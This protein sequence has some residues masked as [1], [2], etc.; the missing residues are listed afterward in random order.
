MVILATLPKENDQNNCITKSITFPAENVKTVEKFSNEKDENPLA[1][2]QSSSRATAI[3]RETQQL[4]I[5][6]NQLRFHLEKESNP[7]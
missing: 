7:Y 5:L 1:E 6:K 2:L 4:T 3:S